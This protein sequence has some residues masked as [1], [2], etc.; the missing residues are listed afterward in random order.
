MLMMQL[1]KS[2]GMLL[3]KD[4]QRFNAQI[5]FLVIFH[6]YLIYSIFNSGRTSENTLLPLIGL[7]NNASKNP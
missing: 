1:S 2:C 6:S 3:V 7:Q 4:Y 5:C